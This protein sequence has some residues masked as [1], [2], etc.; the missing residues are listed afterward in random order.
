[1]SCWHQGHCG[2]HC[3]WPAQ[4]WSFFYSKVLLGRNQSSSCELWSAGYFR[5]L[6]LHNL[7]RSL[8]APLGVLRGSAVLNGFYRL[9]GA[10]IGRGVRLESVA[11][12]DLELIAIDDDASIGRDANLQPAHI[13]D[14]MLFRQPIH[15]QEA[16]ASASVHTLRSLAAQGLRRE[17]IYPVWQWLEAHRIPSSTN[18][19]ADSPASVRQRI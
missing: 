17:R 19:P 12:S 3:S 10:R 15:I 11:L 2:W 8:E 9:C 7:F 13:R 14:G 4:W 16:A 1:M 5:W 18:S 6:F